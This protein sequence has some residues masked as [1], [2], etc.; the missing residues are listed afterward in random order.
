[1]RARH[2][3]FELFDEYLEYDETSSTLLRWKKNPGTRQQKGLEAGGKGRDMYWRL[4]LKGKAWKVHRVI[5]VLTHGSV[6]RDLHVDHADRNKDNN[7]PSNLIAKTCSENCR[8][9]VSGRGK[10][11]RRRNNRWEGHFTMPRSRKY[12][13]VGTY[14]TELEAR[15]A[16]VA[17]R[18]ELYWAI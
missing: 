6:D 11:A 5:Y 18:L 8:N 14:D 1:M 17:R 15:L 10:Y 2:Y 7:H 3:P 4:Q 16:A 9:K 13:H 12:V